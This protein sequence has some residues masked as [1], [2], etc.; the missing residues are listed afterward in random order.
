MKQ[1]NFQDF[2]ILFPDQ[3]QFEPFEELPDYYGIIFDVKGM[4]HQIIH[5]MDLGY[6]ILIYITGEG[7]SRDIPFHKGT[8]HFLPEGVKV[9]WE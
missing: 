7:M 8:E 3:M 5:H 1:F 4:K 6:R 2:Y 9:V